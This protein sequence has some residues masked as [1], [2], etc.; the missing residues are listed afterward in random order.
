MKRY[1]RRKLIDFLTQHLFKTI[2]VDDLLRKNAK[3][4]LMVGG[5]ALTGESEM[6]LREEAE[7]FSSSTLW[8]FMKIESEYHALQ[9]VLRKSETMDDVV[10]GKLLIYLIDVWDAKLRSLTK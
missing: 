5:R 2:T 4:Q 1:L 9:K 7:R 10:S 3:G 6:I 8:K